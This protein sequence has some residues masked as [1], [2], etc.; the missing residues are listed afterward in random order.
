MEYYII[1]YK[2]EGEEKWCVTIFYPYK[3][4]LL[5][6]TIGFMSQTCID[7]LPTRKDILQQLR[8]VGK[9]QSL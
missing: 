3:P 8:S 1:K 5:P 6:R 2:P 9:K 4:P 7:S